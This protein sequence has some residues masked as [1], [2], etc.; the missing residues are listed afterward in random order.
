MKQ[1][2]FLFE[3]L[4]VQ[5]SLWIIQASVLLQSIQIPLVQLNDK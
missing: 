4:A 5:M 1:I 3:S 2:D